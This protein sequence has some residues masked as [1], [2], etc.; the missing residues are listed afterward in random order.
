[1]KRLTVAVLTL[2]SLANS[3]QVLA[4]DCFGINQLGYFEEVD[5][6]AS[7]YSNTSSNGTF[8]ISTS[9]FYE[10]SAAL[11][12]QVTA[13][14]PWQ[15]RMF[16]NACTFDLVNETYYSIEVY[17]K[18]D[19]DNQVSFTLMD[20]STNLISK[21]I[22][23]TSTDW[24]R[25]TISIPSTATTTAGA[26]RINFK[27]IGTYYMDNLT[28]GTTDCSGETAGSAAID[29]CGICAGGST[30]IT[31]NATCNLVAVDKSLLTWEGVLEQEEVNGETRNFRFAK[32]YATTSVSGYYAG[33]RA[34]SSAGM[35]LRFATTSPLINVN[36]VEDL[37]Y[38]DDIFYHDIAIYKNGAFMTNSNDFSFSLENP[39]QDLTE[40]E[41]VM[42]VYTQM[43]LASIEIVDGHSIS[44]PQVTN[45]PIYVAIGNS[46]T[47]GVGATQNGS[48][49]SYP[50]LVADSLGYE[51][52]NWGIGGSKI[53]SNVM[54]NF[55]SGLI[56]DLISVLWGYNDVY[57]ATTDDYLTTTSLPDY[58]LLLDSLCRKFPAAQIMAILPI[59]TNSA[60]ISDDRSIDF[61]KA[62][63]SHIVDSL[64]AVHSNL[65]FIYG[66]DFVSDNSFLNDDAHPNDLGYEALA[67]GIIGKINDPILGLNEAVSTLKFVYPNPTNSIVN[68]P[69]NLY[70]EVYNLSGEKIMDD[71][72]SQANLSPLSSGVYFIKTD[73][74]SFKILKN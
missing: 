57:Y 6:L 26:V 42:P 18:G 36:F 25:Y 61:L 49:L 52:Y 62:G 27:D 60:P 71:T 72:G 14:S 55:D 12:A 8:A 17:L 10:G 69:S 58:S 13:D 4:N 23:L 74:G 2:I 37:S 66:D 11:E 53:Y 51:L 73:E 45:K 32:D 39:N 41:F 48:Y 64:T 59:F 9:T 19:I 31:A 3:A 35:V 1:M 67:H 29:A 7:W 38:A 16:N 50:Y 28:I 15:V 44:S 43:N 22:S 70:F 5:P 40:W 20:G 30:N 65:C 63:Q 56:P 46:I 47:M 21:T 54:S 68:L 24:K 34:S 33:N